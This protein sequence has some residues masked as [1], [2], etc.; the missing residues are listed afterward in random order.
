VAA[1]SVWFLRFKS[2]LTH[3]RCVCPCIERTFDGPDL[4][5]NN[6]SR[7]HST[8][9][10]SGHLQRHSFR[11]GTFSFCVCLSSNENLFYWAFVY[12]VTLNWQQSKRVMPQYTWNCLMNHD[13][14]EGCYHIVWKFVLL[15]ITKFWE[16]WSTFNWGAE[17]LVSWGDT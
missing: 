13:T 5:R 7:R 12:I 6:Q 3:F 4:R 11:G 15:I 16:R 10:P 9:E 1:R 2:H 17:L 8:F 14:S